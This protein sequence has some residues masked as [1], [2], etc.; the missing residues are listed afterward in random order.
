MDELRDLL[1]K[2]ICRVDGIRLL[3]GALDEL[4]KGRNKIVR[5]LTG[6]L[7]DRKDVFGSRRLVALV[8]RALEL[9]NR[10]IDLADTGIENRV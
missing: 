6:F 2:L 1:G 3:A 5:G 9:V 8:V 4:A 7:D 10:V